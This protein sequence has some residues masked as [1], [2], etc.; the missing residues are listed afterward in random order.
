M[1]KRLFLCAAIFTAAAGGTNA[2]SAFKWGAG[3][4]GSAP[5]IGGLSATYRGLDPLYLRIVGHYWQNGPDSN[6]LIGLQTPIVVGRSRGYKIY[7]SPGVVRKSDIYEYEDAYPNYEPADPKD[8]NSQPTPKNWNVREERSE[9]TE[10]AGVL[11]LGVELYIDEWFGIEQQE[12]F[13]INLEFGQGFGRKR[14]YQKNRRRMY[15]S[16]NK[17]ELISDKT[18]ETDETTTQASVVAGIGFTV[19]F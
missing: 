15:D 8:P 17:N 7:L 1:V 5:Y 4:Q 3:L 10:T 18:D 11:L 16:E 14:N 2:E 12:R 9:E 19:Y 6:Y 13:G